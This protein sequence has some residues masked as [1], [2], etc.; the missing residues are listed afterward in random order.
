MQEGVEG[1]LRDKTRKPGKAPLPM[2]TVARCRSGAFA[3][4]R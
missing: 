1:L 2:E 4:A 3:A